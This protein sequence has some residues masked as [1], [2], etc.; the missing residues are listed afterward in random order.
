M[1]SS[2]SSER[3][4]PLNV[5][6][7]QANGLEGLGAVHVPLHANDAPVTHIEDGRGVDHNLDPAALATLELAVEDN[8]PVAGIDELSRLDPVLI[9][10][11]AVFPIEGL[12][13]LA[14][15]T[16]DFAFLEAPDAPMELDVRIDQIRIRDPGPIPAPQEVKC[17]LHD[18]HVLLRHRPQYLAAVRNVALSM[19]SRCL[20]LDGGCALS[21]SPAGVLAPTSR[22]YFRAPASGRAALSARR[23]LR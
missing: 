16:Q 8:H 18:L 3:P 1:S 4:F 2:V 15:A 5:F 20:A 14:E 21:Q 9:P 6:L 19:Q 11:V 22:T 23:A 12:T 10:Y 17:T 13:D 7:R